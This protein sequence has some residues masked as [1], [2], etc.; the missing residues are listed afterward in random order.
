VFKCVSGHAPVELMEMLTFVKCD[1]T[2]KLVARRCNG[3][4]GD[5]AFSVCGPRLWNALPIQ[6][7][8]LKDVDFKANLKTFLFRNGDYF[9]EYVNRK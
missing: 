8:M 2:K 6:L 7:R 1:R 9:N 4:M 3:V 5:R